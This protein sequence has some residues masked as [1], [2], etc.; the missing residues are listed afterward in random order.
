MYEP[1]ILLSLF[2]KLEI[3]KKLSNALRDKITIEESKI[4]CLKASNKMSVYQINIQT[5]MKYFPIILK[6]YNGTHRKNEVEIKMY[7]NPSRKLKEFLPRIYHIERT[8]DETWIFMEFVQQIRG[9]VTFTPDHFNSIIPTLA[10]LH[11][12]TFEKKLRKNENT[13]SEWLPVYGS[14]KMR[15]DRE[16]YINRTIVFLNAAMDD[17]DL[18]DIIKPYYKSLMKIYEKGPDFFPKLLESGSAI[19]HGDLHMQNI[20]SN[21]VSSGSQWNIQFIDWEAAK[22]A[23]VWL[24]MVVLVEVLIGFRKDWQGNA[25]EIRLNCVNVYT[26]EMKKYGIH[27]KENPMDLY[28]M[29]YL[30]RTLEKGLHTQLRRIFDN[31]GG[32]LLAYHLEKIATWGKELGL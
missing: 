9:Q 8:N 20:C 10:K 25:D 3:E 14:D 27:F 19:T 18:E 7:E 17:E 15:K 24:D 31:R 2:Q 21:N 28:K 32:E 4:T 13:W 16:K 11:A 29:A 22:Y 23:P 26:K 30:Q 1:N 12:N 5:K 6:I